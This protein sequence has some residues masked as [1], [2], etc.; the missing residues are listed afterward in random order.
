MPARPDT[1][2]Y[3]A[4]FLHPTPM[5]DMRAPGEFAQGAFPAA[6][7]LPLM[8]DAERAQVGICYKQ[9][10]QDAAGRILLLHTGRIMSGMTSR[11]AA[12]AP[13]HATLQP[14]TRLM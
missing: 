13:E 9:Q 7:S 14:P 10:G 3:R 2:D 1:N 5:M 11:L 8:S 6:L 12:C 4:L